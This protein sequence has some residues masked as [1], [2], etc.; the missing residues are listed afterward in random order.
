MKKFVLAL[1]LFAAATLHAIAPEE[2]LVTAPFTFV[3]TFPTGTRPFYVRYSHNNRFAAVANILSNTV[4]VYKVNRSDGS[5]DPIQTVATGS[6]PATLAY[7][8]CD[9]FACVAN[10]GGASGSVTVYSVNKKTG[11]WTLIQTLVAPTN[12]EILF[13][14][15]AAYS[16]D[17]RFVAIAN[18]GTAATAGDNNISI[19][20]V[21]QKTGKLTL[22]QTVSNPFVNQEVQ[23]LAYSPNGKFLA[24]DFIDVSGNGTVA[25]FAV[26]QTTGQLGA[27]A[28]TSTVGIQPS[29]VTFSHNGNLLT[30]VNLSDSTVSVFTIDL[31]GVLT[32]VAVLPFP[33]PTGGVNPLFLAF[34]R[35]DL[36]AAVPNSNSNNISIFCVDPT[37]GVFGAPTLI[38]TPVNSFPIGI[39]IDPAGEFAAVTFSRPNLVA[40]YR[41]N[42]LFCA[43]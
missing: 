25:T 13:P 11:L 42:E 30:V 39:D 41:V 4:S 15:Q 24:A 14:E 20:K 16:P 5:L 28:D 8:P 9:L 17:G 12:P 43:P 1:S 27:V 10:S 23:F 2:A 29:G 18:T 22:V 3:D 38:A 6:Q 31:A 34:S 32:P 33:I 19:Y 37:T 36:L 40:V 35:H 26:N 21:N 7:A